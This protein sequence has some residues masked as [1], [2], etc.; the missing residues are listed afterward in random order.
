MNI[1]CVLYHPIDCKYPSKGV[2]AWDNYDYSDPKTKLI[3]Y[4]EP[5]T[6][7]KILQRRFPGILIDLE[8]GSQ[9]WICEWDVHLIFED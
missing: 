5:R 7:A 4:L 6:K 1:N 3:K 9:Y 2:C 8:D